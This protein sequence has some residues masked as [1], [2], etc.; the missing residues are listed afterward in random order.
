V[1]LGTGEEIAIRDLAQ[2]IA[3]E[4]GFS[5]RMVWDTTKPNG[6]PRRCLD[7]SRAQESFGFRA[8]QDLREGIAKTVAWFLTHRSKDRLAAVN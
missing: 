4:V 7:V 2:M 3:E 5:G 8:R 1:N 6:Q